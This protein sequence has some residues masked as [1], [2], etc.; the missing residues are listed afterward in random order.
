MTQLE[1]QRG[2]RID[3]D[4]LVA[5]VLRHAP[6]K[7]REALRVKVLEFGDGGDASFT[8]YFPF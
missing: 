6:S 3:G 7:I 2:K 4:I 1:M 5:T 8:L